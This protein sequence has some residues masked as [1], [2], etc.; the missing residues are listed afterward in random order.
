[1]RHALVVIL[2]LASFAATSPPQAPTSATVPLDASTNA[3]IVELTFVKKDGTLR[4]A[5]FVVDTGGGGF[6]LSEPL[7]REIGAERTGPEEQRGLLRAAR[8]AGCS[9]RRHAD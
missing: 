9:A 6:I 7:A 5:R 2:A 3:A 4:T 1:M 8:P